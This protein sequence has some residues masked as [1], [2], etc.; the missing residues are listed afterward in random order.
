MENLILVFNCG[1]SSLKGAV[2]DYKTGDVIISYLAEKLNLPDAYLN[3]HYEGD[4]TLVDL[5]DNP[6]HEGAVDVLM[7]IL[8]ETKL[9]QLIKAVGHRI[10]HGGEFFKD[11]QI[12]TQKVIDGV[13]DC[14]SLAPLHTPANLTGI[15][16]AMRAFSHIPH[17]AVFDTAYHQTM[18]EKAYLYGIP[19]EYYEQYSVRKYGM[20]GT[21]YRYVSDKTNRVLANCDISISR[22]LVAHLGNGASLCAIKDGK[23]VDTT[24]GLTPLEGLI[25]GTRSGNIDANIFSFLQGNANMDIQEITDLLNKKSGLIGI[26]GLSS[27]L[28]VITEAAQEGHVRAQLAIDMFV[29]RIAKLAAGMVVAMGGIEAFVFT[30]GIGQNSALVRK[31][32]LDQL[33]I[34]GFK[35]DD[36]ANETLPSGKVG[37]ISQQGS[38]PIALVV[39]TNEELMIARDTAK[40]VGLMK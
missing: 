11:S 17:V 22:M 8:E 6:T 5:S 33:K 34:F 30:G 16:V 36:E 32:V 1:S 40:L 21:S 26:S 19:Y 23:S 18:P 25:M 38:E 4:K 28:R 3:I 15:R 10:V 29:Y 35:I 27:D 13:D 2:L 7:Q 39:P 24:M 37:F 9:E 12:I 20:H 31:G 14:K